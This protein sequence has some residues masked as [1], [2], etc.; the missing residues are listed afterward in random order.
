MRAS[1]SADSDMGDSGLRFCVFKNVLTNSCLCLLLR[2]SHFEWRDL[3]LQNV[4]YLDTVDA[5][6]KMTAPSFSLFLSFFFRSPSDFSPGSLMQ[7][8]LES[9][10]FAHILMHPPLWNFLSLLL[11]ASAVHLP[12][13]ELCLVLWFFLAEPDRI[14]FPDVYSPWLCPCVPSWPLWSLELLSACCAC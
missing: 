14:V 5:T 12:P 6:Q 8:E 10:T 9:R 13:T 4:W 11:V 1:F 7:K 3:K 2:Y